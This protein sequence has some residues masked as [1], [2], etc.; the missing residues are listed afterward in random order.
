GLTDTQQEYLKEIQSQLSQNVVANS[1]EK[2]YVTGHE[3]NPEELTDAG[4]LRQQ[5]LEDR[6]TTLTFSEEDLYFYLNVP[7]KPASSTVVQ[8]NVL[9]SYGEVGSTRFVA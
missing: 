6:L 5:Q 1:T 8:Y 4:A 3:V 7:R 2:A 9:N